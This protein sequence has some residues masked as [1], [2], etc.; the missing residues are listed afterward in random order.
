MAAQDGEQLIIRNE[1][2]PREGI[3]LGVQVVIETLLAALQSR[4]D[5][6]QVL[7]TVLGVAGVIHQ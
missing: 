1:E 7:Q 6:L 2:E 3:S 4:V 5:H